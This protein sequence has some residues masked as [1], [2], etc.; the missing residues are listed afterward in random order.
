M[1]WLMLAAAGAFEVGFTTSMKYAQG[2][3]RLWPTLAFLA[4]V[5]LSFILLERATQSIPLG[6]AYAVWTGIGAAGTVLVGALLFGETPSALRVVF[7]VTLV[8]SI[9]G[10]KVFT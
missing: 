2:F 1:A 6:T 5:V 10:L 4:C 3:T 9:I 8:G 7:L